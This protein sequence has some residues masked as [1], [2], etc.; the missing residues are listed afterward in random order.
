MP[1]AWVIRTGLT[2]YGGATILAALLYLRTMPTT[3]VALI[4]IGLGMIVTAI[5]PATPISIPFLMLAFSNVDGV[6]ERLMF[7]IS[8]LWIIRQFR[9]T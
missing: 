3:S 1:F 2:A 4:V 6:L 9:P 5:F 8:F 7:A